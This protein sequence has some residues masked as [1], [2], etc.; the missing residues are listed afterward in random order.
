M[1]LLSCK[2]ILDAFAAGAPPRTLL[3]EHTAL[4]IPIWKVRFAAQKEE[5]RGKR[6]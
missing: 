1:L 6:Q 5:I 3:K 4:P 2:C